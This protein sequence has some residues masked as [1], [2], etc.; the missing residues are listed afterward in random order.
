MEK[1]KELYQLSKEIFNEELNRFIRVDEKASKYLSVLTLIAGLTAFFGK[2]MIAN[3]IPP[4]SPL[5]WSLIIMA[6][7][8]FAAI[9]LSWVYIFNA[10]RLH[11]LTKPPLN[12]ETIKFFN[13]NEMIDIYYALTKGNKDALIENRRTT[14]KKSKML[15]R[16]YNAIIV[17]GLLLILFLSLFVIH[18]WNNPEK[19]NQHERSMTMAS[20]DNGKEN[21]EQEKPSSEK[22]NPNITPPAYERVTEGYDPSKIKDKD[23]KKKR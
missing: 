1:Y 6:T 3:L 13:D 5:E 19:M 21:Q 22:P 12:D 2:W 4:K 18:S 10:L 23:K 14:D 17:C 8:L 20:E 11:S 16:G 9:F 7:V 15:Y